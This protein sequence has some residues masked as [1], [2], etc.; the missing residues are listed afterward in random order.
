MNTYVYRPRKVVAC[1]WTGE[2]QGQMR[3]LLDGYVGNPD[4]LSIEIEEEEGNPFAHHMALFFEVGDYGYEVPKGDVLVVPVDDK[5][6]RIEDLDPL[7]IKV[8]S[9][10]EFLDTFVVEGLE[11]T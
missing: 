6:N 10:N 7:G 5:G 11:P 3:D 4:W 8:M 1:I 2:N 9:M